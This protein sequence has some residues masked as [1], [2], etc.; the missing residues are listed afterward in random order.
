MSSP[1]VYEI[2]G[3]WGSSESRWMDPCLVS[4]P[5]SG[6]ETRLRCGETETG[7][8]LRRTGTQTRL[9]GLP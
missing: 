3:T 9:M 7:E 1:P 6:R 4:G 2:P 8:V 5:A